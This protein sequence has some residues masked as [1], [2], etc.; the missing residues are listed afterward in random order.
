MLLS[1]MPLRAVSAR[2][3][4]GSRP[5]SSILRSRPVQPKAVHSFSTA[6]LR[7]SEQERTF[8]EQD[9]GTR[10][11]AATSLPPSA[12]PAYPE[13]VPHG[14]HTPRL[15]GK[16]A[17]ITGAA[18]GLGRAIALAYAS[19]G[20]NLVVCADL[21]PDPE[22]GVERGE[23]AVLPTHELIEKKFGKGRAAFA[24]CDVGEPKDVKEAVE[25]AVR[26]GGGR[27]DM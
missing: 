3:S 26:Q 4:S 27:M 23:D 9:A 20:A 5:L 11:A 21:K 24:K 2:L 10:D 14:G 22:L 16:V 12:A 18:S 25:L 15:H 7:A 17:L 13:T 8:P 19:H 6:L 1:R